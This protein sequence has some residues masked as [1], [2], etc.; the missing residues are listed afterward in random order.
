MLF[1]VLPRRLEITEGRLRLDR[2]VQRHQPA[3]G[4]VEMNTSSVQAG[5][6]LLEPAVIAAVDLDQLTQTITPSAGL[7]DALQPVLPPNP[8][9][10]ANHP[11]PQRL[12]PEIQTMKLGQLLGR[13]GRTKIA[14]ALTHDGQHGLA[15]HQ[16]PSPI[17][18]PAALPRDQTVRAAGAERIEQPVN[19]SSSN[20][21]QPRGVRNR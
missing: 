5:A 17:A 18:R 12:D 13:Q 9:A 11:L 7:V 14:V 3:G 21:E 2:E 20:S 6:P 10:G 19:L 4:V 16:T 8:K 15:E 1:E